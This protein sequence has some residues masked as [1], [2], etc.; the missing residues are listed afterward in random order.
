[1]IVLSTMIVRLF[2]DAFAIARQVVGDSEPG[3][4]N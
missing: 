2:V 3:N 4:S 1:M